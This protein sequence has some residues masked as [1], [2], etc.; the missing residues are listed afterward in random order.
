M[1]FIFLTKNLADTL[2]FSVFL[3]VFSYTSSTWGEEEEGDPGGA[4]GEA[5]ATLT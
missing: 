5:Q 1:A 3:R 2:T 4:E